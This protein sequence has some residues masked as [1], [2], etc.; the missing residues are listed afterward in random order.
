MIHVR[1]VRIGGSVE[2]HGEL[3]GGIRRQE[4]GVLRSGQRVGR[5][6]A[7][8]FEDTELHIVDVEVVRHAVVVVHQPCFGGASG[9]RQIYSIHCH[10]TAVVHSDSVRSSAHAPNPS[11]SAL[12]AVPVPQA[13]PAM[14]AKS[15][16]RAVRSCRH[17]RRIA[18]SRSPVP[19]RVSCCAARCV[20]RAAREPR[21]GRVRQVTT[22]PDRVRRDVPV[23]RRRCRRA[24]NGDRRRSRRCRSAASK[25]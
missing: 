18:V 22:A 9:D 20:R 3:R 14:A 2:P 1:R 17:R 6:R 10:R 11:H 21:S 24:R 16:S 13:I 23:V 12:T 4:N 19:H 8:Q 5:R 7:V 15:M 25:R